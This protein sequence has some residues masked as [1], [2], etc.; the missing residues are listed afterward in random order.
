MT[1][2]SS[3]AQRL[4]L[5]EAS[6]RVYASLS[7][8]PPIFSF[9]EDDDYA[10]IFDEDDDYAQTQEGEQERETNEIVTGSLSDEAQLK[11]EVIK[12]LLTTCDRKTYGQK[13][14]MGT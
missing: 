6:R 13:L 1:E 3:D 2:I 14:R 5:R 11:M 8:V 12:S 10:E 7:D 9:D 4:A